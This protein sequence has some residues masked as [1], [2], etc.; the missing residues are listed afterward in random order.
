MSEFRKI[1]RERLDAQQ[2]G[3]GAHP[4]A[5]LLAAFAEQ[6][7]SPQERQQV[8][9]HLAVC[10]DCRQVVALAFP[11]AEHPEPARSA[12]DSL[13]WHEWWVFRWAGLAAA[14]TVIMVAVYLARPHPRVGQEATA[15]EKASDS[16]ATPVL[17][18]V[19]AP[20]PAASPEQ[21]PAPRREA[22]K[23]SDK[24]VSG[25]A[26]V[27]RPAESY[28]AFAAPKSA[29]VNPP[30]AAADQSVELQAAAPPPARNAAKERASTAATD[31]ME[32]RPPQTSMLNQAVGGGLAGS[33]PAPL[34]KTHKIAATTRWSISESG[35]LQRS[36]NGGR[37][38]NDVDV[39]G[40]T[41]FRTVAAAGSDVWAGGARGALFHSRDGGDHWTRIAVGTAGSPVTAD[42]SRIEPTGAA[43]AVITSTGEKWV[44]ADS[45]AT[46]ALSSEAH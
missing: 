12:E 25:A 26:P 14:L 34:A 32:A 46:W 7:L 20:A 4:D 44:S 45:G 41:G 42:I 11:A 43:I 6:S 2:A 19:A 35:S 24:R 5:D 22:A 15:P 18:H 1:A 23:R 13:A 39:A 38:W 3:G 33:A 29:P 37:T 10:A 36:D 21:K 31:Q 17:P 40:A 16:F 8:V 9:A 28:E 30:A 27:A